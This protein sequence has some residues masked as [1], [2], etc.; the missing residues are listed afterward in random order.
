MNHMASAD[1]NEH[2]SDEDY[3]R[4][5]LCTAHATITINET[6][7]VELADGQ[8]YG[9]SA[10][11]ARNNTRYILNENGERF[12]SV[13]TRSFNSKR[14]YVTP[15]GSVVLDSMSSEDEEDVHRVC[16]RLS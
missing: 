11:G 15:K 3:Y 2:D 12:E 5:M 16:G 6:Q 10:R 1:R 7:N 8:A 4:P 14:A 9:Y 13:M